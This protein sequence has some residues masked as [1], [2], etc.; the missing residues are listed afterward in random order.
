MI[1]R[2]LTKVKVDTT[3]F[4]IHTKLILCLIELNS[5]CIFPCIAN[6]QSKD[7]IK[8]FIWKYINSI[9]I[10]SRLDLIT[11]IAEYQNKI[12][13]DAVEKFKTHFY[14]LILMDKS[15]IAFRVH[16]CPQAG[17]HTR[18]FVF[19]KKWAIAKKTKEQ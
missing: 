16:L 6:S 19:Q 8:Q 5:S 13:I 1:F 15:N 9:S 17:T 18:I 7:Q 14:L 4:K 3:P 12:W 2:W 10:K 11:G